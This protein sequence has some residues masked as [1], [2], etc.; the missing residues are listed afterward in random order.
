[1]N[2]TLQGILYGLGVGLQGFVGHQQGQQGQNIDGVPANAGIPVNVKADTSWMIIVG[3]IAVV[4]L[5]KK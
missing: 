3:I 5:M 2:D 4:L 1:M